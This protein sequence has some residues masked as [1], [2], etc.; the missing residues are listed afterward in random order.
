MV[1]V[2]FTYTG[3]LF[4]QFSKNRFRGNELRKRNLF[5]MIFTYT[6]NG[7]HTCK[8][9][10]LLLK[11]SLEINLTSTTLVDYSLLLETEWLGNSMK[12]YCFTDIGWKRMLKIYK[13]WKRICSTEFLKDSGCRVVSTT[14]LKTKT[15]IF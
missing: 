2:L 4:W 7:M 13:C 11:G 12:L 15:E 8:A 9:E 10:K 6:H 3:R 14:C 1:K 5:S